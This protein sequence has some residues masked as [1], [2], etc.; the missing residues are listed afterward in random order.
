M[1][2]YIEF[3]VKNK[4]VLFLGFSFDCDDMYGN[5]YNVEELVKKYVNPVEF[6]NLNDIHYMNGVCYNKNVPLDDYSLVFIGLVVNKYENYILVESYCKLKDIPFLSHGTPDYINNKYKQ[7]HCIESA[8]L[9][10]PKTYTSFGKYCDTKFIN[11]NFKYPVVLKPAHGSQGKG[12]VIVKNEKELK[13]A[14]NSYEDAPIIIQEFIP[15]DCDYRVFFI[16]DQHVFNVKRTRTD[17]KEFRN[18][19][20]LGGRGERVDLGIEQ[21]SLAKKAHKCLGFYSSGVDLVQNKETDEWYVLEVNSAPQFSIFGPEEVIKIYTDHI[22][23][24]KK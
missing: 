19:V 13:D 22:N 11:K 17:K 15:N 23:K 2:S 9:N 10:T 24:I 12:V 6:S 4:P 5:V 21:L 1:K 3:L 14:S 20:S 18:N 7:L 8:G 16:G